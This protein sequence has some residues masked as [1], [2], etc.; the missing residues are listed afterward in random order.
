MWFLVFK[1]LLSGCIVMAVSEIAKRNPSF[2]ALVASLPLVSVLGMIWLWQ[3]TKDSER[4]AVH[5]GSTFWMVLPSLPMF[6]LLP[7]LL[8]QGCAFYPALGASCLLTV[9]LYFLMVWLLSRLGVYF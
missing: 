3:E 6:L 4:L 7:W 1:A 9:V 8:R 2:G 5:A